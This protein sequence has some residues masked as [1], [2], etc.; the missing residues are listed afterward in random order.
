VIVSSINLGRAEPLA[1]SK[2]PMETGI[3]KRPTT[4]PV[5]IGQL[6]LAGDTICNTENHGGPDQ[7]V[8]LFGD[9]DYAWW[10]RELG[11]PLLPGTFGENLTL[12]D[13]S[14]CDAALGDQ[15]QIGDVV[16]EITAPRIPCG[17]LAAR[18]ADKHFVRRFRDAARPGAYCRVLHGGT[19]RFGDPVVL[20]PYP[21][22]RVL[23]TEVFHDWYAEHRTIATLERMLAAPLASRARMY[24]QMQLEKMRG[25]AALQ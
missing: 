4:E 20:V 17:T 15:L 12:A 10:S 18:M 8:Y 19:V 11:M 6:G 21:G 13:W 1:N 3:Y 5:A 22:E 24:K 2:K 9:I 7:A 14:C 16:L 23:L 25:E